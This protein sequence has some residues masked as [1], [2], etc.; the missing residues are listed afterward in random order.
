MMVVEDELII[1]E[2]VLFKHCEKYMMTK[3]SSLEF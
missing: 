2:I 3:R 1:Y